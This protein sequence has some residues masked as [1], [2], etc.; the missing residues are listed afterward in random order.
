MRPRLPFSLPML[1]RLNASCLVA[2]PA[3]AAGLGFTRKAALLGNRA[4]PSIQPTDRTRTQTSPNCRRRHFIRVRS[5]AGS[6]VR[7]R[8][9]PGIGNLA[10]DLWIV[11]SKRKWGQ[12]QRG[13]A[14]PLEI[15]QNSEPAARADCI[16]SGVHDKAIYRWKS[17]RAARQCLSP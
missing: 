6:C 1:R 2:D 7:P 15:N 5:S 12:R 4:V 14:A 11:F 3:C 9:P 8:N 17:S 16:R 10:R 13:F